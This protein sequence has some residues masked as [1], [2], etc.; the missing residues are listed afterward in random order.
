MLKLLSD[1]MV[2]EVI[3]NENQIYLGKP[4]DLPQALLSVYLYDVQKSKEAGTNGMVHKGLNKQGYPSVYLS[5][6]YMITALVSSD[7]KFRDLEEQKITGRVIQVLNDYP[8]LSKDTYQAAEGNE[9]GNIGIQMLS[10]NREEKN[11]IYNFT[12]NTYRLSLFYQV[13]FIELLSSKERKISRVS[14][15][16]FKYQER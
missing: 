6:Y 11:K 3:P 4:G 9:A 14:E 12:N 8:Y 1:Q 10:L 2:P 16:D 13:S 15:L 7:V 5:L